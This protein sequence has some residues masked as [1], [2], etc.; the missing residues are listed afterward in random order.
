MR[1]SFLIL[2]A[3]ILG[4]LALLAPAEGRH[5]VPATYKGPVTSGGSVTLKIAAT[6]RITRIVLTKVATD[7]GTISSTTTGKIAIVN[8]AFKYSGGGLTFK[9][10]FPAANKARGTLSYRT[11]YPTCASPAVRWSATRR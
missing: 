7:C 4:A 5:S 11:P 1:P 10:S 2:G 6:G 8:H 3:L 9:G